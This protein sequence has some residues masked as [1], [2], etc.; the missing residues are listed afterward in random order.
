LSDG[1]VAAW[2]YNNHGEANIPVGLSNVVAIAGGSYYSLALKSDGTVWGWGGNAQGQ[3]GDGSTTQRLSPT[4]ASS[5][6]SITSVAAGNSFSL[7]VGSD[8]QERGRGT[9][10][11]VLNG[12]GQ[13]AS[14]TGFWA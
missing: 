6:S 9:N 4:Q 14:V 3:L 5:L 10:L 7:A 13:I 8:G 12:E 11:F 2:G 1:T